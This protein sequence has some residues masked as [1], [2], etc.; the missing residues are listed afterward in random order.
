MVVHHSDRKKFKN[1]YHKAPK[2]GP[3]SIKHTLLNDVIAK[4]AFLL[5]VRPSSYAVAQMKAGAI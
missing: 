4:G 1:I 5:K 2:I 3:F